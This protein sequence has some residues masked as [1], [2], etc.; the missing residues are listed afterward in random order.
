MIG[1]SSLCL[2]FNTRVNIR[3]RL[4]MDIYLPYLPS[5]IGVVSNSPSLS[6]KSVLHVSNF[7]KISC[8]LVVLQKP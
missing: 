4:L 8:L 7:S 3:L 2:S 1:V 5:G 6:F